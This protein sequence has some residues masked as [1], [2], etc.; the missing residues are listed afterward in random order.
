[1]TIYRI[2]LERITANPWQTRSTP[3][4]AEYIK[5][6]ALDIAA[7][8]LLQTPIGRIIDAKGQK[9][10][11]VQLEAHG[12]AGAY[13]G[14]EESAVLQLAF[15]HHR[16]AAYKWLY[17][18]RDNSDIEGDWSKMPVDVRALSDEQ[19]AT[20]AWSENEKR[21][22][23]TAIDRARAIRQRQESFEWSNRDCAQALGIDHSTVSNLLRL[24]KLPEDLQQAILEGKLSERQAMSILPVFEAPT[25]VV[26]NSQ[27]YY[28]YS[29]NPEGIKR[30]ALSGESSDE[31]RRKVD[32]FFAYSGKDLSNAEFKLDQIFPEGEAIYCGLCKTCDLR[33]TS[34]NRC[35]NGICFHA[36]TSHVHQDYLYQASQASGYPPVDPNKGGV[37]TRLPWDR[38]KREQIIATGCP[39]LKLEYTSGEDEFCIEGHPH[40]RLVCDK[41]NDSCTCAQGFKAL[42]DLGEV[43]TPA[44][45][46][47]AQGV[48]LESIESEMDG[49]GQ[50]DAGYVTP[51][52]LSAGDLE[53]AARQ[54]RKDRRDVNDQLPAYRKKL[55]EH[56]YQSAVMNR[57]GVFYVALACDCWPRQDVLENMHPIFHLVARKAAN[58][59]MPNSVDSLGDLIEIVGRRL[60][61]L[62]LD[63]MDI[64][65]DEE[66]EIDDGYTEYG[67]DRSRAAEPDA[68]AQSL[69]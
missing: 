44:V 41:R 25:V 10:G 59:I 46:F 14:D 29:S 55:E 57:P 21:R 15:G 6:L 8:G 13:L 22:D 51:L 67:F 50:E 5:E 7:N 68:A 45:K 18:L 65:A 47:T 16:L 69:R 53:D 4:P 62:G 63:A 60:G 19:L 35:F 56:L 49:D 3:P 40:A 39:N 42:G 27:G 54:A 58:V 52:P 26:N 33:M 24:L 12:G 1:M 17:D 48:S 61:Q 64:Q 36:K 37:T 23:I 32:A 66:K 38:E 34:R 31:L 43:Q 30:A 11:N 28:G 2:S 9:V 20:M